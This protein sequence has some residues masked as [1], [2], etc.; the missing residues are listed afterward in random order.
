MIRLVSKLL[1]LMAM[2][3]MPLGMQPVAA[4]PSMAHHATPMQHCPE[5]APRHD[6]KAGFVECTMAC[7]AALPATDLRAQGP[8]L[9]A[10]TPVEPCLAGPLHGL[11]PE[12]ATPPPKRS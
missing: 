9:I 10:C 6:G 8:L 7:S 1:I 5:Q 4:A 3:L 2:L 11:H 12:T